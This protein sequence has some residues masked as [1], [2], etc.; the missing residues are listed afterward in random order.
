M[1]AILIFVGGVVAGALC[2]WLITHK[3]YKRA[4]A[5]LK[6]DLARQ[7]EQLRPK[8][9]LS[10]FERLVDS[11]PWT[12]RHIDMRE[13]WVCDAENTFQIVEGEDSRDFT[14]RWTTVYP[15]RSGSASPIYLKVGSAVIKELTFVSMD[16]RRIFVP[17]AEVR[18]G[19]DGGAEYFWNLNSLEVK[20]CH[21]VGSYYIYNDLEGVARRSGVT[22]VR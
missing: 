9:T 20:V 22:I 17:M 2:S 3:Y 21:V 5:E 4:A 1:G 13:V 18:P 7:T 19:R 6:D 8:N 10:D 11:S 15:D 14:E 16:G 12:K